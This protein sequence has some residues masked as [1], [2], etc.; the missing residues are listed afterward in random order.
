MEQGG[1]PLESPP[2]TFEQAKR[3]VFERLPRRMRQRGYEAVA[4]NELL[5]HCL[6]L[7]A[8]SRLR[9]GLDRGAS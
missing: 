7:G 5:L 1:L 2:E 3:A 8:R 9:S 4:G 6:E